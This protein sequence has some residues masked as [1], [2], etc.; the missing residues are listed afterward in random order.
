MSLFPSRCASYN[1]QAEAGAVLFIT[2]VSLDLP[3]KSA[4]K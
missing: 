2:S 1:A 3:E 4:T